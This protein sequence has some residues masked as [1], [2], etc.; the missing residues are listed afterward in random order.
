MKDAHSDSRFETDVRPD[1]RRRIRVQN[2]VQNYTLK[3][4]I[5][6]L[7]AKR[8]H[9]QG[10]VV[11]LLGFSADTAAAGTRTI[12][13]TLLKYG[14]KVRTFDPPSRHYSQG[15]I[16]DVLLGTD[17]AI[18]ATDHVIFRSLSRRDFKKYGIDIVIP[19]TLHA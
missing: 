10:S 11:A 19:T 3:V 4:L 16:E 5:E 7:R 2:G 12:Y 1:I 6:A 17:A 9:L 8:K 13:D 15:A 14:A 18:I